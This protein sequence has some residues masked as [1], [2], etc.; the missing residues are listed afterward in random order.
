MTGISIGG[1]CGRLS[2]PFTGMSKTKA[3]LI[4]AGVAAAGAAYYFNVPAAIAE[5]MNPKE[6]CEETSRFFGFVT[7]RTCEVPVTF[8]RTAIDSVRGVMSGLGTG[9]MSAMGYGWSAL[10][11]CSDA[12]IYCERAIGIATEA[13]DGL[14]AMVAKKLTGVGAS[15]GVGVGAGILGAKFSRPLKDQIKS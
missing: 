4:G 9:L 12:I 7:D 2:A 13:T 5:C 14:I 15:I 3:A 1:I 8:C 11:A 6:R 10:E